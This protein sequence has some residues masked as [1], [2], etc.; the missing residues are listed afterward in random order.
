MIVKELR[1]GCL[2]TSIVTLRK[3]RIGIGRVLIK[4]RIVNN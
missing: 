1:I 3:V 2:S 4:S